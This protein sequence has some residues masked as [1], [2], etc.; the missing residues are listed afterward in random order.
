[1]KNRIEPELNASR[2]V[3]RQAI[4]SGHAE[5]QRSASIFILAGMAVICAIAQ[6]TSPSEHDSEAATAFRRFLSDPPWIK[7][8]VY[9]RSGDQFLVVIKGEKSR[10]HAGFAWYEAALQPFAAHLHAFIVA[11]DEPNRVIRYWAATGCLILESAAAPA[12][13]TLRARLNDE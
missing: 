7:K 5:P 11:L 3:P 1:M 9:G 4:R 8:I 12:K 13:A 6:E 10:P 2:S